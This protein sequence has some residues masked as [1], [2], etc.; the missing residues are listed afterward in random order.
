MIVF[1][2]DDGSALMVGGVEVIERGSLLLACQYDGDQMREHGGAP[3]ARVRSFRVIPE[4]PHDAVTVGET[5]VLGQ[6]PA[7][8]AAVDRTPAGAILRFVQPETVPA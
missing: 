2:L 5:V 1:T 7:I 3:T 8:L 4:G 6:G